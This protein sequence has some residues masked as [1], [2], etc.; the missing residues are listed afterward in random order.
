[1][2]CRHRKPPEGAFNDDDSCPL[3]RGGPER[4][5]LARPCREAAQR[6]SDRV[7]QP[8][9][10]HDGDLPVHQRDRDRLRRPE[11]HLAPTIT[12]QAY[13]DV[14]AAQDRLSGRCRGRGARRVHRRPPRRCDGDPAHRGEEQRQPRR[15]ATAPLLPCGARVR[16]RTHRRLHTQPPRHR[17]PER[18]A[19]NRRPRGGG[20]PGAQLGLLRRLQ[21]GWHSD[22]GRRDVPAGRASP[23]TPGSR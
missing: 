3:G 14:A 10:P 8:R 5:G 2:G 9:H 7:R 11:D 6:P 17:L 1:M 18:T 21:D 12:R 22:V 19:G 16:T 20:H 4:R 23:S 13:A 15:D